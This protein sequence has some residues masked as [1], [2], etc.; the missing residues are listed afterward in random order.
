ML[1]AKYL[2]ECEANALPAFNSNTLTASQAFKRFKT[3]T[4]NL[5]YGFYS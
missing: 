4:S 5:P 3:E 1:G 2:R